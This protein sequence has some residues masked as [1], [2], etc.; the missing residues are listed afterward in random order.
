[1]AGNLSQVAKRLI[2]ALNSKGYKMTMST[3]Q[4]IGTEGQP[5]NY[6]TICNAEWNEDINKYL[7][8]ELYSTTSMVRIV[9]YLR[10]TWYLCNGWELPTDQDKWNTI[11]EDIN[12]SLL[13]EVKKD[14]KHR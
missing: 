1:M 8:K 13:K 10:D 5:H 7:N 9:L 4:F 11:R 3:K 12:Y 14:G 2:T 6:Y